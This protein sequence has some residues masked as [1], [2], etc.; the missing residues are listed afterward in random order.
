MAAKPETVFRKR[1]TADLNALQHAAIF[2]IQQKTIEGDPDFMLCVNSR[3]VAI[4]LKWG[5]N[6][7][8]KLQ[9]YKLNKIRNVARGIALVAWPHNWDSILAMLH[10]MAGQQ[11]IPKADHH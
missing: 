11:P 6:A 7:P 10:T 8:T 5:K 3:F 2:P 4:E 9:E 1:V